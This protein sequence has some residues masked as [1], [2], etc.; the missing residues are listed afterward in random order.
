MKNKPIETVFKERLANHQ[1]DAPAGSWEAILNGLDEKKKKRPVAIW[2]WSA[3]AL[4][5]V[6]L[7]GSLWIANS[8]TSETS[9][10]TTDGSPITP[11]QQPESTQHINSEGIVQ[12]GTSPTLSTDTQENLVVNQLE[13]STPTKENQIEIDPN[14]AIVQQTQKTNKHRTNS[15]QTEP[16][17]AVS[18]T[19]ALATHSES[20]RAPKKAHQTNQQEKNEA[21]SNPIQEKNNSFA[22]AKS[23]QLAQTELNQSNSN[24]SENQQA[25]LENQ[26][27]I[28][29][30]KL[31]DNS[32]AVAQSY[33]ENDSLVAQELAQL[34]AI[35]QQKDLANSDLKEKENVGNK[36]GWQVGVMASPVFTQANGNGSP[37]DPKFTDAEKSYDTQLSFGVA[38]QYAIDQRWKLKTGINKMNISMNTHDLYVTQASNGQHMPYVKS[39]LQGQYMAVNTI[40]P[41]APMYAISSKTANMKH[42]MEFL[43]IPTEVAYVFWNDS[44]WNAHVSVGASTLIHVNN[45]IQLEFA[46]SDVNIG[47]SNNINTVHFSGNFGLGLQYQLWREM[48]LQIEPNL[49]YHL[50]SFDHTSQFKPLNLGISTGL[51]YRF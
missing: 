46:A 2:W 32:N 7:G 45:T 26:H 38:A 11:T 13:S 39:S 27:L 4:L 12:A 28:D 50:N 21:Y 24:Q 40:S 14:E 31:K 16:T 47:E 23:E 19:E 29:D 20:A 30:S 3:A 9:L 8:D 35:E 37:I 34:Q 15:N 6:S 44:K 17:K 48:A 51:L 1:V 33:S 18:K 43:E 42:Q 10:T 22:N 41:L 49:K 36:K 25:R 5:A